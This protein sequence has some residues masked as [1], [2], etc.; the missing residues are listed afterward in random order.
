LGWRLYLP[1]EWC[2]DELRRA[3]AKITAAVAFET[4]AQLAGGLIERAAGWQIPLAPILADCAYGDDTRFRSTLHARELEYLLAVSAKV[5]VY[6]P[7]TSFAVPARDGSTGRPRI[8]ARPD[9]SRSRCARSLS[10][11]LK[12][13][14]VDQSIVAPPAGP[15]AEY[16]AGT[17]L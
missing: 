4:K 13:W 6:G 8:V 14:W 3:R 17:P 5:S 1:Q 2:E 12:C 9:A 11:W 7:E 15:A 10:G 16:T